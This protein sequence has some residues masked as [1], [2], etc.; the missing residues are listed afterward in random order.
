MANKGVRWNPLHVLR[1]TAEK[2]TL[3]LKPCK[4]WG[5]NLIFLLYGSSAQNILL[6]VKNYFNWFCN[7][8]VVRYFS[9]LHYR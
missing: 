1:V 8:E 5:S 4:I 3:S 7:I 2:V 9:V 6:V